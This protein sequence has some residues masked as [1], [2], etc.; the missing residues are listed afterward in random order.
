MRWT[1]QDVQ[2]LPSDVYDDL[3]RW[4]VQQDGDGE[5]VMDMDV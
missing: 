4:L 1:W 3:V 2:D 5:D